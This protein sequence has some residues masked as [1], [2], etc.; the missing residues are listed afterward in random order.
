MMCCYDA[1]TLGKLWG[2]IFLGNVWG[3][4]R[5]LWVVL[6]RNVYDQKQNVN[7]FFKPEHKHFGNRM[8]FVNQGKFKM[9]TKF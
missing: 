3:D 5:L 2:S 1:S 6:V 4:A 9:C 8:K 7:R